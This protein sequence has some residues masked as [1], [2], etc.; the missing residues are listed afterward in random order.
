MKKTIKNS[1]HS[2]E[3]IIVHE[4]KKRRSATKDL[5]NAVK[6]KNQ[7]EETPHDDVVVVDVEDDDCNHDLVDV[8]DNGD[9]DD[10]EHE[11]YCR[12][13]FDHGYHL[14]K[15][16]MGHS[17]EDY[18]VADTKTVKGHNLGLYAI[19]DGHSGHDVADYLQNHLFDNI[20]SQPDFWRNPKKAIKRAYKST[21]DYILH[22]VVGPRGGSTAVTAIVIDGKRIVVANVGDSRAILCRESDVVKQVTVDHEPEKE[23]DI[24][25]SRGGFVYQEP[26]NVPRVDGQ[27]AMTRAFG[28]GR[29]KEHIS[30]TPNVEIVEI[31]DDTKFLILASDGLWKVMSNEEVWD[32]IKKEGNAEEAARTLTD[33]ALARGSK[34]DTSCV[35]VSFLQSID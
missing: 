13:E 28:D 2:P 34:D 6:L 3:K 24:V 29:L 21:D 26:G 22:N 16:Q 14:V 10:E 15:G 32:Q 7:E 12:R 30:V 33:K 27:L 4:V 17:M 5:K 1:T 9:D 19:F 20:L 25:E 11:R 35:V 31:H 18:I 8:D 23:R